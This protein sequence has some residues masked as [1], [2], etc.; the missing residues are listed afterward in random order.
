MFKA[1]NRE[2]AKAKVKYFVK[3]KLNCEDKHYE[4]VHKQVL[5]IREEAVELKEG[6]SISETTELKTWGC[7]AKGASTLKAEFNKN[8]FTP[9]DTAEGVIKIDNSACGLAVTKVSF[10]ILQVVTQKVGGHHQTESKTIVHEEVDGPA[11]NEGDWE[12][13]LAIDLSK[14]KYEVADTKKKKG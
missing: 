3:A 1:D 9:A 8:V 7:C 13:T 2:K 11:A 4:M 14:I 6:T 10:S 12:K 5:S